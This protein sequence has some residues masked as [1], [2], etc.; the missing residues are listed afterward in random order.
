MAIVNNG[1][2]RDEARGHNERESSANKG[3]DKE[4]AKI[5]AQYDALLGEH[6]DVSIVFSGLSKSIQNDL[7]A[8]IASTIESGKWMRPQTSAVAHS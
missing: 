4:L 2:L 3:N 7:K 8:S 6:M 1:S 5:I